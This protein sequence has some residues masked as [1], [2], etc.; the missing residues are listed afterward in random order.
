[1]SE[2]VIITDETPEIIKVLDIL[3]EV[4]TIKEPAFYNGLSTYQLYIRE[5]TDNP[6]LSLTEWLNQITGQDGIT[7]RVGENFNWFVGDIDTGVLARGTNGDTPVIGVNGNW[8]ISGEDTGHNAVAPT[9]QYIIDYAQPKKGGDDHY[10]SALQ[11]LSIA[12]IDDKIDRSE[13]LTASEIQLLI[14]NLVD[15]S[16]ESLNTLKEFSTA[17]GNDPNFATTITGLIG[18]KVSSVTGKSLILDTEILRL[19]TVT[20][21][22]LIGLGGI[23]IDQT[24]PQ[25]IGTTGSRLSKLWATDLALTNMPT[26][27]GVS[28]ADKFVSQ[29]GG[30]TY[31]SR[32]KT[33]Y[34]TISTTGT[35]VSGTG[36]WMDNSIISAR[37]VVNGETRLITAWTDYT[38]FTVD[39]AFSQNYTNANYA[40]YYPEI[41]VVN[42][43]LYLTDSNGGFALSVQ[44]GQIGILQLQTGGNGIG[45]NDNLI[46]VGSGRKISFANSSALGDTDLSI[47]RNA[48]NT[49]EINNGT[50]GTLAGLKLATLYAN[51]IVPNADSTTALQIM[52]ADGVTSVLTVNTV[53]SSITTTI[54]RLAA[55]GAILGANN[56]L[57]LSQYVMLMNDNNGVIFGNA[58]SGSSAQL[59]FYNKGADAGRIS[60]GLRWLIGSTVD[61]GTDRLQ[62]NGSGY[63][64]GELTTNGGLQT[65]GANDSAGAGYRLVRVPNV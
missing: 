8:W 34:G 42:G 35:S 64:N 63:F 46:G 16:P 9:T 2:N 33:T 6:K 30:M 4:I 61:N 44:N 47:K 60:N 18:S 13:T 65:F 19:S 36:I 40:V 51:K 54:I 45:I 50:A 11:I 29:N 41:L 62:V 24:A 48:A 22:T 12:K 7:P 39:T 31:H 5:T 1:M 32:P 14:S 10:V 15:S 49:L 27:G 17:L 58:N 28:I 25:T 3:P 55:A 38:H 57:T 26:V 43:N 20:N 53:D 56:S 21:Q 59:I 37:I 52:K 23:S